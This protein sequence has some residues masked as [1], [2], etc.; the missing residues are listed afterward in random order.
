MS[1]II[2][3]TGGIASGKSTVVATIRK[4]GYQVI[5]ADA[6]VHD[7][8]A[9]GG[10]LYQALVDYFG[11]EIL[12]DEGNL[13]RPTLSRLIFESEEALRI[14]SELQDQIIREELA[15][16]RDELAQTEDV[17]FMDI[18]LLIERGYQDWFDAIWLLYVDKEIQIQRLM[19][20]NQYSRKEAEQRIGAQMPLEEKISFADVLLDNN[21]SVADLEEKAQALLQQLK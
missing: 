1:K 19:A 6:V 20:R 5:D 15:F 17:F 12:D 3:L 10:K 4:A 7:L 2:G 13:H 16:R 21:G 18:P 8:Q 9:K 11:R 14:S